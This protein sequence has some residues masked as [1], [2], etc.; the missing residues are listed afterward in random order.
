M[1]FI[2]R[3]LSV[4]PEEERKTA[5]VTA[6]GEVIEIQDQTHRKLGS[7]QISFIAIGG[8]IG[9]ALFVSI[10]LGL[11]RGG[12][13]SLLIGFLYYSTVIVCVNNCQAEMTV[14]FPVTAPFQRM[15]GKWVDEAFGFAVGWNYFIYVI[16]AL[17][18][19]LGFWW[20]NVPLAAVCGICIVLYALI[21]IFAV[22]WYG[23]AEFWLSIG[24]ILLIFIVYGFTL[25]TMSGGNPQHDAYGFSHWDDPAPFKEYIHTGAL[26]RFQ[27]VLAGI[28]LAGGVICGPEFI[29]MVAGEAKNPRKDMSSA[30]KTMYWRFTVFFLLGALAVGIVLPANDPNLAAIWDGSGGKSGAGSS[31]YVIAMSNMH[32]RGL[33]HLC[34]F[35]LCTSIFSAGNSYVYCATRALYG[36]A[37]NGQAPKFF[38]QVTRHGIPIWCFIVSIALS[39]LSFLQVSNG[40]GVVLTWL[41]NIITAAQQLDYIYMCIT[42]LR[43]KRALEAQ[44]I[45]RKTLP[46]V[47]W[48]TTFCA[49][50]GLA[51]CSFVVIMQGYQVFYPSLW[52]VGNFFTWYCMLILAVVFYPGWKLIKRTKT[53]KPGEADLVWER[54]IIDSYEATLVDEKV[55]FFRDV[56]RMATGAFSKQHGPPVP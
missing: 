37:L 33:P 46:Y 56:W 32:I 2:T 45:D 8:S 50:W 28:F 29:C 39:C 12:A 48:H 1:D 10:G 23:E 25:V 30:F 15:A 14:F 5:S 17:Y 55:P 4:A 49:W 42:Y 18:I 44:G 13:A 51:G 11:W 34:N 26:G 20:D 24:K 36:L 31:P 6:T 27:G 41:V 38:R 7:R 43:F 22:K 19:V 40:S 35:L 53:V 9:T 16:C 52:S 21:N 3:K 47:G 54:P